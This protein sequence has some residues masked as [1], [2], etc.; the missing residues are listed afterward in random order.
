MSE[1]RVRRPVADR[2]LPCSCLFAP[3]PTAEMSN[4]LLHWPSFQVQ[5][6]GVSRPL[7][8]IHPHLWL[9]LN[10]NWSDFFSIHVSE[11][12]ICVSQ[13]V[14]FELGLFV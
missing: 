2:E 10:R 12:F 5:R 8:V 9:L 3:T 13:L 7:L 14:K 6:H 4:L 11:G 1:S